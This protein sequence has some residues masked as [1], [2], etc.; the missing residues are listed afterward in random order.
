MPFPSFK[1]RDHA[2]Q[3]IKK[4]FAK[5]VEARRKTINDKQYEDLLQT[6]LTGSYVK[7]NDGRKFNTDEVSGLLIALLMAG[8]HTSSTS[9]SWFG[10]FTAHAGLQDKLY[11]EQLAAMKGTSGALQL[12]DLDRMPLLHACVRETLR[13][14]PPIMQLMRRARKSFEVTAKGKTYTIP[15]LCWTRRDV[16]TMLCSW[17]LSKDGC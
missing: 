4:R 8:Q 2:H 9:S 1:R 15:K 13:L 14:R 5:V 3:E 11:E 17:L 7:V 12:T 10:F 6:F 16:N